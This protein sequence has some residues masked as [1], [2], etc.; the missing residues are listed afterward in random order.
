MKI[1]RETAAFGT[2]SA[3]KFL[4]ELLIFREH[5]WHHCYSSID[6]YGAHNLPQWARDSWRDT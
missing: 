2:K 1:A 6:P 4:D 5:A 3:D